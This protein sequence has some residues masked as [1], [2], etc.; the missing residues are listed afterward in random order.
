[1]S[2]P[3]EPPA[4]APGGLSSRVFAWL[5]LLRVPNFAT[6]P[7]DPLAGFFLAGGVAWGASHWNAVLAV[8]ISLCLYSVGMLLNDLVDVEDDCRDRPSR[9]LPRGA[10]PPAHVRAII[11]ALVLAAGGM[12]LVAGR[13]TFAVATCL[14]IAVF[15]YNLWAKRVSGIGVLVMGLCRGLSVLVGASCVT[16]LGEAPNLV[17]IGTGFVVAYIV[18][19][20]VVARREM[21][22]SKLR[23]LRWLPCIACAAIGAI[24]GTLGVVR[25]SPARLFA[26]GLYAVLLAVTLFAAM[27]IGRA[28]APAEGHGAKPLVPAQIGSLIRATVFLQ[29]ALILSAGSSSIHVAAAA[30]VAVLWIPGRILGRWLYAS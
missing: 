7:G 28:T 24:L 5:Q 15:A 27:R 29:A 1:M 9:P 22:P 4:S 20:S 26:L 3:T 11:S 16:G 23:S 10:I 21:D 2:A 8:G 6:V 14:A 12:S 25:E 17:F 18:S 19:V 30:A 13:W